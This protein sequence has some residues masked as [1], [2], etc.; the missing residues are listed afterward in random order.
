MVSSSR[1]RRATRSAAPPAGPRTSSPA[2]T[3]GVVIQ[4]GGDNLLV[5]NLIGTTAG[6]SNALGN[7]LDG[8]TVDRSPGNTIGGTAAGAANVIAGNGQAGVDLTGV[9]TTG[10]VINGNFI[11]TNSFGSDSMGNGSDGVLV[12]A[13]AAGNTIGGTAAGAGNTIAYNLAS[14]VAIESGNGNAVVSN[15]IFTNELMGINLSRG[16]QRRDQP[17]G[18]RGRH[19]GRGHQHDQCPVD[20]HRAGDGDL[21]VR[22]LQQR[23]RRSLGEL[24]GPDADRLG[25]LE[26]QCRRRRLVHRRTFPARSHRDSRSPRR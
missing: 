9:A 21:P 2:I 17:T 10:T 1:G 20:L 11:G 4:F 19:P 12:Q 26:R 18:R 8:I 24:R 3:P 23:V 25:H 16:S 22:V 14:G 6:G 13:G 7:T 5:G 15:A